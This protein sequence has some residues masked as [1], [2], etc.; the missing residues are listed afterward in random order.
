MPP[1][2]G[3]QKS[4]ASIARWEQEVDRYP[5]ALLRVRTVGD[6]RAAKTSGRTYQDL[7][8]AITPHLA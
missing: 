1:D 8:P 3:Y 5:A 4:V 6:I 2:E 7:L